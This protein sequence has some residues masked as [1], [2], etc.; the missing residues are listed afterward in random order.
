MSTENQPREKTLRTLRLQRGLSQQ[1]LAKA[2]GVSWRTV[3]DWERGKYYP[4]FDKAVKL[5]QALQ[6]SLGDLAEAM[7]FDPNHPN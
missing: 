5:S 7:G 6:T 1:E 3:S 4:A 2:L